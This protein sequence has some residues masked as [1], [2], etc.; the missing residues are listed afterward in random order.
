MKLKSQPLGTVSGIDSLQGGKFFG[1]PYDGTEGPLSKQVVHDRLKLHASAGRCGAVK[2]R[3]QQIDVIQLL[4]IA[5]D[6]QQTKLF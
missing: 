2:I 3:F 1:A 6:I 5:L 4:N